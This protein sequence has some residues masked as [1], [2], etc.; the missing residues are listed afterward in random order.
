[1]R[2]LLVAITIGSLLTATTGPTAPVAAPVRTGTARV[3]VTGDGF[4]LKELCS[5]APAFSNRDYVWSN[6]PKGVEGWRYTQTAG[7]SRARVHL[8]V[9]APG[10]IFAAV[11]T[12]QMLD[13][14]ERGWTLELPSRAN[15][16]SYTDTNLTLMIMMSLEVKAGQELD[17]PQLGWAGTLVLLPR[18][19]V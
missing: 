9:K 18:A 14:K 3:E 10:R 8:K 11:A 17:L 7:G 15:T 16:F 4:V 5:G 19:A 1:M 12:N 6:V 13:L 2:L